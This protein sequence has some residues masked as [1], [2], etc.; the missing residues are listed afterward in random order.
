MMDKRPATMQIIS[1]L[2]IAAKTLLAIFTG[3]ALAGGLA[4]LR[5]PEATLPDSF[6]GRHP[7][8]PWACVIIATVIL[9]LTI[10]RWV[11]ILPGILGYA[12]LGGLIMV[13]SG[14]YG[15][16]VVPRPIALA[17]ML[18]AIAGT[19][20]TMS[21]A[22]RPLT[23]IDRVALLAFVFCL[24]FSMSA[25]ISSASI[26]LGIG[27]AFLLIAWVIDRIMGGGRHTASRHRMHGS[28]TDGINQR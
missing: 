2:A 10:D 16:M 7:F 14:H 17:L 11:T 18:Y 6:I 24:A 23:L 13:T 9:I 27:S 3:G 25:S 20:L 12:T 15:K 8:T 28:A 4:V 1:G 21:F 26:A 19:G 22:R 5:K